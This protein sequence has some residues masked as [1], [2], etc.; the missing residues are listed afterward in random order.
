VRASRRDT[1]QLSCKFLG[2]RTQCRAAILL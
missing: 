1:P 2:H